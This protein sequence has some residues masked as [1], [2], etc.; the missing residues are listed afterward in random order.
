MATN[1]SQAGEQDK[2]V[3]GQFLARYTDE[4]YLVFRLLFAFIVALHG[5]QKAFLMWGFPSAHPLGWKVD[6]AGWVEFIAALLIASGIFTRLGA[7][8]LCVVMV[9]AYFDVHFG[10]GAGAPHLFPAMGGFGAHGGE[11]PILWFT[12]AGIIGVM[13]SRKYGLERLILKKEIL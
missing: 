6:V 9:V 4:F 7:G 13:G 12:I 2:P 10:N 8:A 3:F 11:V 5:A 1:A